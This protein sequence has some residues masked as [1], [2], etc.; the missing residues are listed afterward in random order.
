MADAKATTVIVIG[1]GTMGRAAIARLLQGD[2]AVTAVEVSASARESLQ[3]ENAQ[4]DASG[5]LR[6][7]SSLGDPDLGD[8]RVALLFLPTESVIQSVLAPSGTLRRF[9]SVDTIVDFGTNSATFA[10]STAQIA[11][12]V[13]VCYL[14]APVLGRPD[15]VGQWVVP[16]GGDAEAHKLVLPIVELLAVNAP[17]VGAAGAA[18]VFKLLNQLMFGAINV[19]TAEIAA[20]AAAAGVDARA[21]FETVTGSSAATVSGLF[22]EI[23]RRIVANDYASPTFTID[24]LAKDV[25]LSLDLARSVGVAAPL[26]REIAFSTTRAQENGLGQLDTAAAWLALRDR[27]DDIG[28]DRGED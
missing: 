13:H 1:A 28:G 27:R 9:G 8:A 6:V 15:K 12:D 18:T 24:L 4:A 14:D 5:Q 7:L 17:L 19:A 20:I 21:F 3:A 16:M 2:T 11:A 22:R 25:G 26:I 10:R 23:G